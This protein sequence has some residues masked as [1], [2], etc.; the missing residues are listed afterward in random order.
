MLERPSLAK[1]YQE[2][3]ED[4]RKSKESVTKADEEGGLADTMGENAQIDPEQDTPFIKP[5]VLSFSHEPDTHCLVSQYDA[6]IRRRNQRFLPL[7]SLCLE[8]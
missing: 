2:M 1:L 6:R 5:Y 7:N 4:E 3:R 8:Y